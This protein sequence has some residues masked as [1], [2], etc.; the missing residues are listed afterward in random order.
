MRAAIQINDLAGR[1]ES[2][3]NARMIVDAIANLFTEGSP[4]TLPAEWVT[5]NVR[6]RIAHA[7]YQGVADAS[8]LIPEQR[9]ADLWNKYV[10]EIG[11]PEETLVNAAE[12]HSVRD[13]SYANACLMWPKWQSIWTMPNIY[14]VRSDGKVADACRA[15]DALRLIFE[16]HNL[17]ENVG[18]ARERLE[19]GIVFS[20]Q[21]NRA[22]EERTGR[23]KTRSKVELRHSSNPILSAEFRYIAERGTHHFKR[24]RQGLFNELFP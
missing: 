24:L 3:A 22:Q 11:A 17:F 13:A 9:I 23:Q 21:V 12:I 18:L 15:V 2:E 4:P 16:M 1:I 7:E 5:S 14:P 20:D 8:R 10:R 6:K 19:K